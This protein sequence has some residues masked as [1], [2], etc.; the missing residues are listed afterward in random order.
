MIIFGLLSNYQV[1]KLK[2]I[3]IKNHVKQKQKIKFSILNSS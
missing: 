1:N 2:N 3:K